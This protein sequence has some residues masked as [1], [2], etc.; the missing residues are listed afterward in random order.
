MQ[1]KRIVSIIALGAVEGAGAS[2]IIIGAAMIVNPT[3]DDF[4]GIVWVVLGTAA[5]T[6]AFLRLHAFF[7]ETRK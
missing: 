2:T 6:I 3:L 7:K 4:R 1:S 5:M